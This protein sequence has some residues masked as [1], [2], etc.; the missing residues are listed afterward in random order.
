M[1]RG[2]A[3]W[4]FPL[5]DICM[6]MTWFV[7]AWNHSAYQIGKSLSGLFERSC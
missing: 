5:T 1:E 4:I 7:I 6:S 3:L 2:Q